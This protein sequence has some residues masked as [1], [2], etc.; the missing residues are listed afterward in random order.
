M[1]V[2]EGGQARS[3]KV[4][5]NIGHFKFEKDFQVD[6][7]SRKLDYTGLELEREV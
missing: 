2:D 3:N 5:F 1:G 4:L 7:F 6:M